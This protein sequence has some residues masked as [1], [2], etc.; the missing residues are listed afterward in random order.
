MSLDK[1]HELCDL[2]VS[3][4]GRRAGSHWLQP[5]DRSHAVKH[6]VH[7]FQTSPPPFLLVLSLHLDLSV[8]TL[9]ISERIFSEVTNVRVEFTQRREIVN[10]FLLL[11]RHVLDF[12]AVIY[13]VHIRTT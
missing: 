8:L 7:G 9:L 5:I 10:C 1:F 6:Q 2:C 3:G 4:T 11:S 12:S 13:P